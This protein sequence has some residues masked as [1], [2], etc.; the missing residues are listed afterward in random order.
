MTR[1]LSPET[2]LELFRNS[3]S[4]TSGRSFLD[5]DWLQFSTTP[6]D[7]SIIRLA[8]SGAVPHQLVYASWPKKRL[9]GIDSGCSQSELDDQRSLNFGQFSR[10]HRK[11][12]FENNLLSG[13][14]IFG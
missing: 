8:P 13:S 3:L 7:K 12:R 1:S 11:M 10:I 6:P 14:Q 5:P 2:P 9:A 4:E